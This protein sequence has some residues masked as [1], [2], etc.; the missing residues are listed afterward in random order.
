[1]YTY[2]V[3]KR[4]PEE[5]EREY[6]LRINWKNHT[7]QPTAIQLRKCKGDLNE[8]MRQTKNKSVKDS[9][10]GFFRGECRRPRRH[11]SKSQ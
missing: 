5:K 7:L 8:L 2:D 6:K 3:H 11:F 4:E 9:R 1:M 10:R